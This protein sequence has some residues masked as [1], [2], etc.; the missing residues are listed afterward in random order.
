M[1]FMPAYVSG[2][3]TVS[4]KIARL[5]PRNPAVS[6]PTVMSDILMYDSQ[7]GVLLAEVPGESLT[8]I[9]TAASSAVAT[10]LLARRHV[11]CLGL[12]GTGRQAEAH[13]PAIQQVRDISRVVVY[14]RDN[15]RREAFAR[16]ISRNHKVKAFVASSPEEVVKES[17]LIVTATTSHTHYSR[18]N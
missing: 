16:D 2:Q 6:L 1:F 8:A 15:D 10:D 4:V 5:N 14:S 11:E 13:V 18:E 17:D 7:S 3:G 12:F 9:R